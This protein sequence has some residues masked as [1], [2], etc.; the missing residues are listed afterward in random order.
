MQLNFA[1]TTIPTI[2]LWGLGLA[3]FLV[4]GLIGYFNLS[5]DARKKMDTADQKIELA[6]AEAERKIAEA[7]KMLD[8]AKALSAQTPKVVNEPAILR[9]KSNDGFRFQIEMDG[10]L[11]NAPLTPER[12]KRLIELLGYIR[13]WLEGATAA[14]QPVPSSQPVSTPVAAPQ[15]T[16]TPVSIPMPPPTVKPVTLSLNPVKPKPDPETEFK[17]LSMVKQIDT[18][19]QRRIEGT[20]MEGLGIHLNDTPQGGLEVIIGLQRYDTIDDVPDPNIIAAIR[21]AIAEWEKKYVPGAS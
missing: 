3:I 5:I 2:L 8:E 1:T 20:P 17:L 7:Q 21:A 14:P 10:Q 11:L 19:L 16:P 4:G 6:R 15:I 13:P 18:V 9:L 12:K